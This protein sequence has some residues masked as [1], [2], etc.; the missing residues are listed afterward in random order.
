MKRIKIISI[1]LLASLVSSLLIGE[2]ILRFAFGFCDAVLMRADDD[3]EY[4][5]Q[6]NQKRRR[7][8]CRIIYNS[9]SVRSEELRPDALKILCVGDSLING[10]TLTD[11]NDLAT[12]ILSHQL[13]EEIQQDVQVL[14]ISAGS[15]GPDN[16]AAYLKKHGIFGAKAIVLVTSSHDAHDTM[17]FVPIVGRLKYFP[18]RQ[19]SLA[20]LE[21]YDRYIRKHQSSS[22]LT[23]DEADANFRREHHI[24]QNAGEFNSGFLMLKQIAEENGIPFILY[25]HP[26]RYEK[27]QGKYN[28]QGQEILSFCE[29]YGIDVINE[30]QHGITEECYRKNDYIH[31]ST[32]GQK[33]LSDNLK[34]KLVKILGKYKRSTK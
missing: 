17:T 7:F 28:S 33:K 25:L 30:M 14:N 2:L 24:E 20:L 9:Y 34:V 19:Y 4:I 6:P 18:T 3:Y 13:S 21:L 31:Y 16:N 12:T 10:G 32:I 1:W 23:K 11:H 5:A 26:E 15:W 8:G 27:Q 22:W 29:Q